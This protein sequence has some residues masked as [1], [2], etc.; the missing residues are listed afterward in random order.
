MKKIKKL[1][2]LMILSVMIISLC[3]CSPLITYAEQKNK[4]TEEIKIDETIIEEEQ[5]ELID[6]KTADELIVYAQDKLA[7]RNNYTSYASTE[8]AVDPNLMGLKLSSGLISKT[9]IDAEG[10]G[11]ATDICNSYQGWLNGQYAVETY[12][13]KNSDK[14]AY[15]E[16]HNVHLQ[17][18]EPTFEGDFVQTSM[19]AGLAEF[20]YIDNSNFVKITK[21]N[22]KKVNCFEKCDNY[23]K[24]SITLKFSSGKEIKQKFFKCAGLEAL[25]VLK[26]F[27]I[28]FIT[29]LYG[30]IQSAT[31]HIKCTGLKR[32][33]Y[34]QLNIHANLSV[35]LETTF[36]QRITY[37]TKESVQYPQGVNI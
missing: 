15:R 7:K 2:I 18:S 34:N 35:D 14:I 28:T 9:V 8:I 21:D 17:T 12:F 4:E 22:I 1:N 25:P 11:Y 31:Y 23:Y 16:T 19:E 5:D 29:D 6:F 32:I 36:T 26:N 3:F 33:D 20:G 13:N 30:N 37:G 10:K 24:T 27:E